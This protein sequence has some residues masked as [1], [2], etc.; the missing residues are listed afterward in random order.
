MSLWSNYYNKL[1]RSR[2]LRPLKLPIHSHEALARAKSAEDKKKWA[3]RTPSDSIVRD[4]FEEHHS[5]ATPD[6]VVCL[7]SQSSHDCWYFSSNLCYVSWQFP[8]YCYLNIALLPSLYRSLWANSSMLTKLPI[9]LWCGYSWSPSCQVWY[10]SHYPE[11][12]KRILRQLMSCW[13]AHVTPSAGDSILPYLSLS[14]RCRVLEYHVSQLS[15]TPQQPVL[16]FKQKPPGSMNL[17][18]PLPKLT[19]L[20]CGVRCVVRTNQLHHAVTLLLQIDRVHSIEV[21]SR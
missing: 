15:S 9:T 13:E 18:W 2:I 3:D 5:K 7:G 21:S 16:V 19:R 1:L 17:D 10:T 20:T 6:D 4:W 12:M 14:E 8:E 11:E